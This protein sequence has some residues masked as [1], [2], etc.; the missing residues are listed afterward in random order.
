[1][2]LEPRS[3]NENKIKFYAAIIPKIVQRTQDRIADSDIVRST[4]DALMIAKQESAD[5]RRFEVNIT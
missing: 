5:T 1:M 4:L 2:E 3:A